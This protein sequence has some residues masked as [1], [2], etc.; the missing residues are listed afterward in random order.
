MGNYIPNGD[1]RYSQ[2]NNAYSM[3][4]MYENTSKNPNSNANQQL[5]KDPN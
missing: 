2:Q 4:N 1:Y 3:N 5:M